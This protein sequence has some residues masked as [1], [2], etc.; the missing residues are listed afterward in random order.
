[1][2]AFYNL[3]NREIWLKRGSQVSDVKLAS[4][5]DA[6]RQTFIYVLCLLEVSLRLARVGGV[7]ISS[8]YKKV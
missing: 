2:I 4:F 3:Q 1:M 6:C 5:K 7:Y 8:P